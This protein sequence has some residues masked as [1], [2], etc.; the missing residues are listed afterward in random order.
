MKINKRRTGGEPVRRLTVWSHGFGGVLSQL[1][2]R[3]VFVKDKKNL[4]N[5]KY[6]PLRRL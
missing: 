6:P 4:S 1:E 3:K 5:F 2:Y